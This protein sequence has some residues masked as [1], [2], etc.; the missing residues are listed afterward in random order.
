[1]KFSVPPLNEGPRR[2]KCTPS[3]GRHA[4]K[5]CYSP[6]RTCPKCSLP[7]SAV[8][9]A[10]FRGVCRFLWPERDGLRHLE[11]GL[12][13]T[14]AL[15]GQPVLTSRFRGPFLYES[16]AWRIVETRRRL[17]AV[18]REAPRLLARIQPGT[19]A[20]PAAV[21]SA[22]LLRGFVFYSLAQ[23]HV[24]AEAP[25]SPRHP[26]AWW[27]R[28]ADLGALEHLGDG[29]AV[30]SSKR[31]WLAPLLAEEGVI[32]AVPELDIPSVRLPGVTRKHTAYL[33]RS[34][35]DKFYSSLRIQDAKFM[36]EEQ[37]QLTVLMILNN[38]NEYK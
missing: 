21:R 13:F 23:E 33:L 30:L 7:S 8:D 20:S 31:H 5:R 15:D 34:I 26:R 1:M 38:M 11:A 22:W 35:K 2:E 28:A 25:L 19:G 37:T 12:H 27:V 4:A 32:P 17:R 29:F 9:L 10:G 14:V 24:T 36:N 16:L 18:E 6:S 3:K